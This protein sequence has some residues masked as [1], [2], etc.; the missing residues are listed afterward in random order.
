MH[1]LKFSTQSTSYL[2]AKSVTQ[3]SSDK[4]IYK[5][6]WIGVFIYNITPNLQVF[7]LN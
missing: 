2:E 5:N 6:T 1:P 7:L 3:G 4:S